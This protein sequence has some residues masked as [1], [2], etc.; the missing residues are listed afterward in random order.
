MDTAVDLIFRNAIHN[1]KL[2]L[3]NQVR[4]TLLGE[5][6]ADLAFSSG[7]AFTFAEDRTQ[8]SVRLDEIDRTGSLKA[9]RKGVK[10][11]PRDIQA[12]TSKLL[13]A[14]RTAPG[15]GIEYLGKQLDMSTKELALSVKKLLASKQ[16]TAK[17]QRRGT[18]YFVKG[19]AK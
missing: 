3:M 10:R 1:V 11:D 13:A 6:A 4:N 5:T 9:K 14:I 7:S 18:R 17:G 15:S 16:I 2:E 19:G 8:P 12:T